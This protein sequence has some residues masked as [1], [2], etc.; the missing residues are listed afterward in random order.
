MKTIKPYTIENYRNYGKITVPAGVAVTHQTASGIDPEYHF[1][2]QFDWIKKDYPEISHPMMLP[3]DVVHYGINVPKEYINVYQEELFD[4]IFEEYASNG[5]TPKFE[6]MCKSLDDTQFEAFVNHQDVITWYDR[7]DDGERGEMQ[8]REFMLR[9]ASARNTSE[10]LKQLT[11]DL[12]RDKG[13]IGRKVCTTCAGKDV[14][15]KIAKVGMLSSC[16]EVIIA[17]QPITWGD[18]TYTTTAVYIPMMHDSFL[19]K[20]YLID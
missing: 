12:V 4:E 16:Y 3:H 2:N 1:V 8:F 9:V 5:V 13:I 19:R 18:D 20:A 10:P 15:G 14:E 6:D 7:L 11:L 17:H